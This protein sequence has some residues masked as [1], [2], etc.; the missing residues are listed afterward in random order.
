MNE[1]PQKTS[2]V[3]LHDFSL[4]FDKTKIRYIKVIAKNVGRCPAWH[5]GAGGKSWIFVDE[6][7]VE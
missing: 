5:P 1:I 3:I 6:I 7:I 2:D 4:S